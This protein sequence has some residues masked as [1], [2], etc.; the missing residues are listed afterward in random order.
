MLSDTVIYARRAVE[1]LRSGVPSLPAVEALG[2]DEP[3]VTGAFEERLDA[4]NRRDG[5]PIPGFLVEGDFGTGKSHVLRYFENVSLKRQLAVSSVTIS[6]ETPLGDLPAVF[7]SAIASLKYPDGRIGGSLA[8]V[9]EQL[10]TNSAGYAGFYRSVCDEALGLDP[11]FQA[12]VLLYDR[13]AGDPEVVEQ[14]VEFWDGGPAQL[15]AWKRLLKDVESAPKLDR[16]AA[17]SRC[18]DFASFHWPC[19]PRATRDG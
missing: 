4:L 1:S 15:A 3:D 18:S 8:E 2:L 7:R 6:K 16:A 9:F 13:H 19:G 5:K 12:S 11:I 17:I 14:L 10:D